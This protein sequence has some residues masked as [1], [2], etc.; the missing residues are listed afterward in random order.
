VK[1]TVVFR[2]R[3]IAYKERGSEL[4]QRLVERLDEVAKV[5]QSP[6]MEGRSMVMILAPEKKKKLEAKAEPSKEKEG[7]TNA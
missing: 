5:D 7:N 1:A 6:R 4:L 3:Q 2:G